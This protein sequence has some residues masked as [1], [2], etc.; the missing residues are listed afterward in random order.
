MSTGSSF[1]LGLLLTFLLNGLELDV[2]EEVLFLF[3]YSEL[4]RFCPFHDVVAHRVQ[5]AVDHARPIFG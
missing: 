3:P 4:V 5:V 1:G 2:V